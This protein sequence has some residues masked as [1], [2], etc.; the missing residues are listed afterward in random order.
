MVS[1]VKYGAETKNCNTHRDIQIETVNETET[2]Q[3]IYTLLRSNFSTF[4]ATKWNACSIM[5]SDWL[6]TDIQIM[7]ENK[8]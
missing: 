4:Y 5:V 2:E 3:K 8:M 7:D 6:T 1:E